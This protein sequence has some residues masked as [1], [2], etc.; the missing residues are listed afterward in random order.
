MVASMKLQDILCRMYV[1]KDGVATIRKTLK[2]KTDSK[3][4]MA[5]GKVF[6]HPFAGIEKNPDIKIEVVT[7]KDTHISF[8][9]WSHAESDTPYYVVRLD[10]FQRKGKFHTFS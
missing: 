5:K 3:S 6:K 7:G 2:D 4:V 1:T 8:V 10:D 9:G